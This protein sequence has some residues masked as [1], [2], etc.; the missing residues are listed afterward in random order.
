M[1]KL[2]DF[3]KILFERPG[4]W[5]D[6]TKGEKRKHFFIVNQFMSI[7]FPLQAQALNHIK[8]NQEASMDFWQ[9]FMR[10]RYNKVPFWMFIKGKVKRTEIKEKKTISKTLILEYCKAHTLDPKTI[11]DALLHFADEIIK[12][13]KKFDKIRKQ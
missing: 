2:F 4:E 10:Q 7:I 3:T 8:I 11:N 6:L 9:K 1:K 13:I 12:E 5:L